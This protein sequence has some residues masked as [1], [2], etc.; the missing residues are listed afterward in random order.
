MR[1][2]FFA[3]RPKIVLQH[4]VIPGSH[5]QRPQPVSTDVSDRRGHG[6]EPNLDLPGDKIGH[7]G[8]IAAITHVLKVGADHCIEQL[9]G[10]VAY[11]PNRSA[12]LRHLP[13]PDTENF[14]GE[15]SSLW[16]MC[17]SA[18]PQNA[19]GAHE[20]RS[21]SVRVIRPP[22]ARSLSLI[23]RNVG[24]SADSSTTKLH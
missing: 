16:P 10:Q 8:T 24:T 19:E 22:G 14:Y 20:P 12:T 9:S 21:F 17:L 4:G 7:R 3:P 13:L 18:L 6:R 15:V 11:G 1:K 2:I 5:R 23:S